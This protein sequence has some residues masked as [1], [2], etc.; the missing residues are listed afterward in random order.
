[1]VG[2]IFLGRNIKVVSVIISLF[3][4]SINLVGQQEAYAGYAWGDDGG[5]YSDTTINYDCTGSRGWSRCP[6]WIKVSKSVYDGIISNNRIDGTYSGLNQCKN[7]SYTIIAGYIKNSTGTL[8][9]RNLSRDI[10]PNKV[11]HIL[12]GTA[13]S[14]VNVNVSINSSWTNETAWPP[15]RGFFSEKAGTYRGE[16]IT[17]GKLMSL[18]MEQNKVSEKN[19]AAFCMSM[20]KE[21]DAFQ[22]RIE[23]S[24]A[25]SDAVGYTK[26]SEAKTVTIPNCSATDGC[27]VRFSDYIRRTAG[28]GTTSYSI[29]R[30][31]NLP[32]KVSASNVVKNGNS[33]SASGEK[34]TTDPL[35]GFYKLY[36]GMV[37]CESLSFKAFPGDSND[38]KVSLCASALGN[39]QPTGSE[40][41]SLL[42]IKVK[43]ERIANTFRREVYA[44]PRDN[45]VYK[46]TYNP[47]LQYTYYLISQQMRINGGT[48]YPAS[49]INKTLTLGNMFNANK[50]SLQNWNNAFSVQ[51]G[52]N[53]DYKWLVQFDGNNYVRL[54]SGATTR[55]EKENNVLVK[56]SDVGQIINE[57]AITNMNK[58]AQTTPSQVIF[59]DNGGKNMGN[60]ITSSINDV[61]VTKVPYNFINSISF[62]D[63]PDDSDKTVLYAGESDLVKGLVITV[64]PKEN[65]R[66][67]STYATIVRRPK[68]EVRLCYRINI[69]DEET[70]EIKIKEYDSLN[71]GNDVDIFKTNSYSVGEIA[72]NIPDVPAGTKM[73]V[74]ASVYP[75]TSGADDNLSLEGDKK[76][77][78]VA[79][80]CYNVAKRPSLQ[81][82]GGNIYSNGAIS[83]ALVNK[84]RLANHNDGDYTFGSW[85]ELGIISNGKVT[86]L[87]SGAGLG[88]YTTTNDNGE[89]VFIPG[90]L[91]GGFCKASTL[92]F[93][94]DKCNEKTVG[95]LG[96][97]LPLQQAEKDRDS[98]IRQLTALEGDVGL[99]SFRNRQ[100]EDYPI[101]DNIVNDANAGVL[102]DLPKVVIYAKNIYID[103]SVTRIDAVLIAEGEVNT[104]S[105]ESGKSPEKNEAARSNQLRINGAVIAGKLIANRTYGAA[106]GDYSMVPAEIINFDPTLYL[107]GKSV[108]EN[109]ANM[110]LLTTYLHELSP[111]Y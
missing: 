92:S 28:E 37:V 96:T 34:L 93:A 104:C 16:D 99:I 88:G 17:Y 22:G 4:A 6:Q 40:D 74:R 50:G 31:S 54:T 8:Y 53:D 87:A 89:S 60:V 11:S 3:V 67:N 111:R 14:S 63:K 57:K 86:G 58:D 42:S 48:I 71:G 84:K 69:N 25:V 66:V 78:N 24:G 101:A 12:L 51:K 106:T 70:C 20:L 30:S 1:M 61:A 7:D 105:D 2:K 65:R 43:N 64:A 98:I 32:S 102:E 44:K 45:V 15:R 108:S 73:C 110:S 107:W 95:L 59:T 82:W 46:T 35:N 109:E 47:V 10:S 72:I 103:C 77:S 5:N 56:S 52:F 55:T 13:T 19:L 68:V 100:G 94:N 9:L 27:N 49:D 91:A 39:A 79:E 76:W 23:I 85:G 21:E 90:G 26:E 41:N 75:A 29:A 36:P 62:T 38:K 81:V 80:K 18:I 97:T 33:G 83:T